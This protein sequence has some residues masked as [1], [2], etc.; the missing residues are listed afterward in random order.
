MNADV[1]AAEGQALAALLL[2]LGADDWDR[3][4]DCVEWTVRDLTAH[5]VAQGEGARFPW[6]ALRRT[7]TGARR[8]PDRTG[9]D[10]YTA[11]QV[12]E[13]AGESGPQLAGAFAVGWPKAVAAMRRTPGFVR[14]ATI[15]SGI[16]GEPR[17][18]I[19]YLYDSILP[20]DLW[21]HRIDI[22][23]ATGREWTP[24]DHDPS[25]VDDVMRDL[26]RRW[27]GP[28]VR[29]ELVGP[30]GGTWSL[31]SGPAHGTV[32]ADPVDYLRTLAGRAPAPDLA[33]VEGEPAV[34][35]AVGAARLVF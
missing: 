9:L 7:R 34:L 8:F 20:R 31:G 24:H 2:A 16:P 3:P 19:G 5:L 27:S 32:A 12:A 35:A 29:V 10:A 26:A 13:H 23:R 22:C 17:M 4:T 6:V 15:D 11:Q 30:A 14:R 25:I 28:P 33:L 18:S 21:M 1:A